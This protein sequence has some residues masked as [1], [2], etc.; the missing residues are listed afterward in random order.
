M[1]FTHMPEL[2]WT[3]GYPFALAAMVVASIVLYLAFKRRGWM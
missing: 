2:E 1:N 3:Y